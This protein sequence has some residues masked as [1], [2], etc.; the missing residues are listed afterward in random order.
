MDA[1]ISIEKLKDNQLIKMLKVKFNFGKIL[2]I[3]QIIL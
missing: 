3:I 1:G 2:I